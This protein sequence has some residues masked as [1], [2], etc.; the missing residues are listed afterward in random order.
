MTLERKISGKP[1]FTVW[2]VVWPAPSPDLSH[3]KFHLLGYL[4]ERVDQG[5]LRAVTELKEATSKE[6]TSTDSEVEKAVIDSMKKRAEECIQSRGHH[7][8]N[9]FIREIIGYNFWS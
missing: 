5:N 3:L 8:R 4:K 1:Y 9:C 2:N 7:F 6:I